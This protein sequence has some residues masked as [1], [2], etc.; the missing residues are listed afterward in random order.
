MWPF[1]FFFHHIIFFDLT[2]L[3]CARAIIWEFYVHH[4]FISE[5]RGRGPHEILI[6][7]T[8]I[9]KAAVDPFS[10]FSHSTIPSKLLLSLVVFSSSS[11]SFKEKTAIYRER[12]RRKRRKRIAGIKLSAHFSD[13]RHGG[14]DKTSGIAAGGVSSCRRRQRGEGGGGGGGGGGE[15]EMGGVRGGGE[16]AELDSAADGRGDT[17]AVH[18]SGDIGHDGRPPRRALPL[19]HRHLHVPL[20][21]HRLQRNGTSFVF[22]PSSFFFFFIFFYL[23]SSRCLSLGLSL[24]RLI[25]FVLCL[26]TCLEWIHMAWSTPFF[27]FFKVS[28]YRI[29]K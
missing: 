11:H 7:P 15:E 22:F 16:A 29:E 3:T 5:K 8:G 4:E 6:A 28:S 19:Q 18:G 17:V 9:L 12:W 1:F 13:V 23:F 27:F 25:G 10:V 21:R 26:R 20:R 24:P 14:E 2:V